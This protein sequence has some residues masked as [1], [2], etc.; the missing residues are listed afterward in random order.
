[1]HPKMR[2]LKKTSRIPRDTP[3][4]RASLQLVMLF[5]MCAACRVVSSADPPTPSSM[6]TFAS[7][8]DVPG[9]VGKK[10]PCETPQMEECPVRIR[11]SS[12]IL[13]EGLP[14]KAGSVLTEWEE[15]YTATLAR[16][17]N[18]KDVW[19]KG[20][21]SVQIYFGWRG[22]LL[23]DQVI[24]SVPCRGL[25]FVA[26]DVDDHLAMCTLGSAWRAGDADLPVGTELNFYDEKLKYAKLSQSILINGSN[27]AA[28]TQ[29]T[30]DDKGQIVN[31]FMPH[32]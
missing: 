26:F 19:L 10:L 16:D 8:A 27:I 18:F 9:S 31:A 12:E 6:S 14:L 2:T 30:F 13:V 17:V 4:M 23:Q 7:F 25:N 28:G 15:D 3:W 24:A 11:L 20:G 5:Y 21:T 1:V 22:T 32:K 29:L